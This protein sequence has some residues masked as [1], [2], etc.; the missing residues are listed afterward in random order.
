VYRLVVSLLDPLSLGLFCA[1]AATAVLW[2]K[3]RDHRR[4][5]ACLIAILLVLAISSTDLIGSL[6][7]GTLERMY[8]PESSLPAHAGAIV[9][10]GS[11]TRVIEGPQEHVEL[12]PSGV[13]RCIHA[14]EVYRRTG[15]CPVIVSGGKVSPRAP[16][17]PPAEAMRDLLIHLGVAP[18]DVVAE[19]ASRTTYENAVY[20]RE[21]LDDRNLGDVVLV[22]DAAHMF[23]SVGCFR[24]VGMDV[25]PAACNYQ[26]TALSWTADT[27]L[28]A[29]WSARKTEAAVHEW[30][31]IAWYWLC[32]RI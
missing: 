30:L 2:R 3:C 31:G 15:P 9:V 18:T 26:A 4:C 21:L 29:A 32:G 28:P 17:P 20:S 12:D 7:I 6:T 14:A 19:T 23:R 5:L 10:L 24:E 22:T 13:F 1:L 25:T 11:G 16:G 27:F 8:P